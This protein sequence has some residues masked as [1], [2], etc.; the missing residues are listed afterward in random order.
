M[1]SPRPGYIN[2]NGAKTIAPANTAVTFTNPDTHL[3]L[4][5][6]TALSAGSI[7]FNMR[8]IE[9]HGLILY[10]GGRPGTPDFIAIEMYDGILYLVLDL[11]GGPQRYK[12]SDDRV[13]DG[14]PHYVLVNRNGRNLQT[15]LDEQTQQHRLPPGR[16]YNLDLGTH[17][18][19]GGVDD[20]TAP[21]L[22][23][24]LWTRNPKFY[25][26]CIW[27]LVLN[28]GIPV[29][30]PMYAREQNPFVRPGCADNTMACEAG[31]CMHGVCQ[32]TW[33]PPY[34]SCDC[35][36]SDYTGKRCHI[37]TS[38]LPLFCLILQLA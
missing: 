17:L 7:A 33:R 26:G 38:L 22:P 19:L 31:P 20:D 5:P 4:P 13:D 9:A 8:T 10:N 6:Y 2:I 36:E 24:H 34:Y 27:G 30:L 21:D 11:G 29:D 35:S 28:D 32:S 16:D 14:E 1:R 3:Q 37:G 18:F 23:W 15:T 12:F 25:T